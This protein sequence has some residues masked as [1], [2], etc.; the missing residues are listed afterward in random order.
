MAQTLGQITALGG[1]NVVQVCIL[2]S[3]TATNSAPAQTTDGVSVDA[4]RAAFGGT[5]P[6]IVKLIVKSTAGSATMT[7]TLRLWEL[8][9]TVAT[10][11]APS[12]TGA[13]ATKGV[14]NGGAA[15]GETGANVINHCEPVYGLHQASRIY[16]EITAIGGTSTAIEVY[17]Q[18]E[19][20]TA[21]AQ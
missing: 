4:L 19:R 6:D 8:N 9:G 3:A 1:G 13:D 15:L 14:L 18:A 12:G 7:A 17:L 2:A 5:M 10:D 11:W 16:V 20:T 21:R